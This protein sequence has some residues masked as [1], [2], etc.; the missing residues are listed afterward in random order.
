LI[1]PTYV[2]WRAGTTNR[3]VVRARQAGN[4]FPGSLKGL[5][6]RALGYNVQESLGSACFPS[7]PP[8]IPSPFRKPLQTF[9]KVTVWAYDERQKGEYYS[10]LVKVVI[11]N[12]VLSKS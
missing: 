6:I 4:R 12:E 2:A 1:S 3:V 10:A 5:Q 11:F 9:E 7:T 8:L